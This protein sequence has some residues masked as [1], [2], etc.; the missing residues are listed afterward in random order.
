MA[1]RLKES[2]AVRQLHAQ[3]AVTHALAESASLR[4]AAPKVLQAICETLGWEHGALWRVD[5]AA[6][7]LR[8]VEVWN[9]PG[10][11]FPEFAAIEPEHD[12]R[13]RGRACPGRVWA[14]ASRPGFPTS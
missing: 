13:A 4:E 11:S 8:C 1:G 10:A 9:P 5:G 7:L 6:E 3:Y 14:T 12:L 2:D